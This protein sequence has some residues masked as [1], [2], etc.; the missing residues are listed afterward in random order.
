MTETTDVLP[1]LPTGDRRRALTA[2]SEAVWSITIVDAAL[3]R[4][5]S[6]AY[7]AAAAELTGAQRQ[8]TE[9]TLAGLRF[10]RNQIG[11]KVDLGDLV[12]PR[13]PDAAASP[14]TDWVWKSVPRPD[15]ASRSSRAQAWETRR[16][17]AYQAQLAGHTVGDCVD[18]AV[19]FLHRIAAGARTPADAHSTR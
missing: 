17:R 11:Q 3:V 1:N 16:Y 4:H 6:P 10:V 9:E 14:A 15:L 19:A 7:D 18:R 2:I 8:V 5:L 13:T 12:G